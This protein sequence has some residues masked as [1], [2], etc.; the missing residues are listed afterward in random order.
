M[1][2]QWWFVFMLV[3]VGILVMTVAVGPI[4]EVVGIFLCCN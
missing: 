4:Y 3:L 2:W 1:C